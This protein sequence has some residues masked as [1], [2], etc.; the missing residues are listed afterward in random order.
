LH[1]KLQVSND[2]SYSFDEAE[3]SYMPQLDASRDRALIELLPEYLAEDITFS[4]PQAAR[5]YSRVVDTL[6]RKVEL[7]SEADEDDEE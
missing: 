3:F 2:P 5:F 7:E 4:R 1:F 6:T